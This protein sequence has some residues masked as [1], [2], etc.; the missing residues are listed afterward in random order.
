R[1]RLRCPGARHN[2]SGERPMTEGRK[3]GF[4]H[5]IA[6]RV[7]KEFKPPLT[8]EAFEDMIRRRRQCGRRGEER[9]AKLR[10]N[11]MHL[12]MH[13]APRCEARPRSG[14]S[15]RSP[16]MRNCRCRLHGGKSTGPPKGNKNA[17]KHGRY[18]AQAI[19]RRREVR[20]L[21]K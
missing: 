2:P 3:P 14:T 6:R 15:C 7:E 16:A 10:N 13:R 17:C 20:A 5:E 4:W 1:A 12:P 21:L 8:D 9:R 11:P 18:T 19:V